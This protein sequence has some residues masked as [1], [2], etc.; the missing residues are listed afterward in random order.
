MQ[1]Q[2]HDP[3]I[4]YFFYPVEQNKD[5]SIVIQAGKSDLLLVSF[6]NISC[7]KTRNLILCFCVNV[8]NE[9]SFSLSSD[10]E[11]AWEN[12]YIYFL[13]TQKEQI[14]SYL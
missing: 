6:K 7:V 3:F 12:E 2:L 5:F 4:I 11:Q 10:Q 1:N 8:S 9:T 13:N 14:L